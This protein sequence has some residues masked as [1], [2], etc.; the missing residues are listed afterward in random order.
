MINIFYK[1]K[2]MKTLIKRSFFILMVPVGMTT[3]HAQTVE[4]ITNKYVDAIGGKTV[5][6]NLKSIIIESSIDVMGNE[7][8]STTY[9]LVG[10]GFKSETDLQGQKMVQALTPDGGWMINPMAGSTTATALPADQAKASAMQLELPSNPLANYAA[11]GIKVELIG[12]DSADFK[13]QA[14]TP[15]LTATYYINMKTYLLDKQVSKISAGGQ[16]VETTVTYSDYRKT[17]AGYVL[18]YTSTLELPQITL[19]IN[20][21]KVTVNG[22]IDPAIFAMPK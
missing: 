15:G 14:T 13:L 16:E 19:T 21:K 17:D 22:T 7:A 11:K 18:A 9:I 4:D 3:L 10:K 20:L 8:P 5:L 12:K 6:S 2:Y 1:N